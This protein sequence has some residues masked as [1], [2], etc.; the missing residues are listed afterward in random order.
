MAIIKKILTLSLSVIILAGCGLFYK[1]SLK[2]K[3]P[4][5]IDL[6]NTIIF[7]ADTN[8]NEL[9]DPQI[10]AVKVDS[11]HTLYQLTNTRYP[12]SDP[13]WL[14]DGSGIM[15]LSRRFDT[16]KDNYIGWADDPEI[17]II[18]TVGT[19]RIVKCW[20]NLPKKE[21][22]KYDYI[23][24]GY[25]RNKPIFT[26]DKVLYNVMGNRLIIQDTVTSEV[27]LRYIDRN[28]L[29]LSKFGEFVLSPDEQKLAFVSRDKEEEF[30]WPDPHS[31][32]ITDFQLSL[33][34]ISIMNIEGTGYKRLTNNKVPDDH[35][36]WSKDG[37]SIY[38][39]RVPN[40]EF[41]DEENSHRDI[42][43]MNSDGTNQRNLTDSPTT[44][45]HSPE[46]SPDGKYIA[47]VSSREEEYTEIWI[48]NTN[49]SDRHRILKLHSFGIGALSWSPK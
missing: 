18:D 1:K 48:M 27:S 30:P 41:E 3:L 34:E 6:T 2:E 45:D 29:G 28:P 21:R 36:C 17:Y 13:V 43:V 19:R 25:I 15:F 39:D 26:S 16:Y 5:D 35:P 12:L 32:D 42:F 40:W 46:C 24:N 9:Y 49:G 4:S 11:P 8:S 22:E 20:Y 33:E 38:F 14:P 44:D 47:Y 31:V 10:F 7:E 23:L 37:K